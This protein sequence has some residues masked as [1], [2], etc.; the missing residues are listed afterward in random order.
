MNEASLSAQRRRV[1]EDQLL[2]AARQV[3]AEKGLA[4]TMDDLAAMHID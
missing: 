1:T 4:A 2:R 3:A